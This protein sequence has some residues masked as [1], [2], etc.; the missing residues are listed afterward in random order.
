MVSIPP[1]DS[2]RLWPGPISLAHPFWMT[3]C[4]MAP[5]A[6]RDQ[7]TLR[8]TQLVQVEPAERQLRKQL[9]VFDVMNHRRSSGLPADLTIPV[10]GPQH[11]G[12]ELAPLA[13]DIKRMNVA[14]GNQADQPI[15]K[16]LCH[17]NKKRAQTETAFRGIGSGSVAQTL[18]DIH[19]GLLA[20][21]PAVNRE[22]LHPC[23]WEQL[24]HLALPASRTQEPS[25]SCFNFT[26]SLHFWQSFFR[27]FL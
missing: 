20:A 13:R 24:Q 26:T 16:H 8:D 2:D 3:D 1:L 23:F 27:P 10:I 15:K 7:V 22:I 14:G 4:L 12:R 17:S 18:G 25:F 19:D 5:P 21:D 9:D 6:H 11:L